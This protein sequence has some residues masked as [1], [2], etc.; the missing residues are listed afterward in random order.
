MEHLGDRRLRNRFEVVGTL[1]GVVDFVGHGRVVDISTLGLLVLCT[2]APPIDSTL[3]LRL[4][5]L[6]HEASVTVRVRHFRPIGQPAGSEYL[7]GFEF[8]SLSRAL[9][10]VIQQVVPAETSE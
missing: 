4:I 7:V 10:A 5:L 6:G 3:L 9:E 1:G 8:L 2:T